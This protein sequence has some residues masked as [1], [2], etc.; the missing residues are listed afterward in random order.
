MRIRDFSRIPSESFHTETNGDRSSQIRFNSQLTT[1]SLFYHSFFS[2]FHFI[3]SLMLQMASRGKQLSTRCYSPPLSEW[4]D[5]DVHHFVQQLDGFIS[6]LQEALDSTENWTQPKQELDSLR[7]YLDTH[8]SFKLNVDSHGA[9]KESI[10]E[11]GRVLLSVITSHKSAGLKDILLMVSSQWD[12]LQR[13]IR[14]QH[15]W[16]L[17]AL[18]C[19]QA[20]LF[21]AG[22]SHEPAPTSG[23]PPANQQGPADGLKGVGTRPSFGHQE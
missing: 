18:R 10:M 11:D 8:L 5:G 15:G 1:Y 6:W 19:I 20:R 17:H 9:L 21:H 22:Q 13:Q 23:D 14:R 7:A 4:Q 3:L 12:Q 2:S 16:M